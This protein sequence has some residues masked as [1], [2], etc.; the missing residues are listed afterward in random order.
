MSKEGT[1]F[2]VGVLVMLAPFSGLPLS[3]LAWILVVL[4]AIVIIVAYFVRK[5]RMARPAPLPPPPPM[6]RP[7]EDVSAEPHPSAFG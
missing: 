2:T 3:W 4:G 6:P 7:A 5:D 1:L